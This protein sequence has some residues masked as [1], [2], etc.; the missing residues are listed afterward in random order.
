MNN[1]HRPG[2]RPGRIPN[3]PRAYPAGDRPTVPTPIGGDG[4][5]TRQHRPAAPSGKPKT[6]PTAQQLKIIKAT[7]KITERHT[8]N[9]AQ[10]RT[11]RKCRQTIFAGLDAHTLALDVNLDP[12]P[13]NR[14]QQYAAIILGWNL[15]DINQ[16]GH[17]NWRTHKETIN[18]PPP[19]GTTRHT[20]HT[21]WQ[22]IPNKQPP[23]PQKT[24]Q[25]DTSE[26]PPF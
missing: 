26:R 5:V 6:K 3:T 25:P 9:K 18:R 10:Q 14:Q 20:K 23:T 17:I 15:Y 24:L 12:T 19:P 7:G 22:P 21:C 8:S 4:T 16:T 2:H 11:C 13:L 1:T